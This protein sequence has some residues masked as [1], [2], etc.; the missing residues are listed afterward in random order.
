MTA[1]SVGQGAPL[2]RDARALLCPIFAVIGHIDRFH[3]FPQASVISSILAPGSAW[4]CIH[5]CRL[6]DN[7][8]DPLHGMS[9]EGNDG[10]WWPVT[11]SFLRIAAVASKPS[12]SGI[13]TSIKATSKLC[14]SSASKAIFP[15]GTTMTLWPRFERIRT[16]SSRL[17]ALSSASRNPKVI[18]RFLKRMSCDQHRTLVSLLAL[19]LEL[20]G[21]LPAA[22]IGGQAW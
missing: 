9:G 7:A 21:W 16:V 12:I 10:R 20:A 17:M 8:R 19:T 4:K 11:R 13:C 22:P 18:P 6:P 1:R 3:C 2:S 15:L 14:A 5:P